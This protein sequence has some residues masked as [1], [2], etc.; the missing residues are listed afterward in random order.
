MV[1]LRSEP[2][3][4][5]ATSASA[6]HTRCKTEQGYGLCLPG[7]QQRALAAL[8]C[9]TEPHSSFGLRV[10]LAVCGLTRESWRV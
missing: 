8:T 10:Y 9:D 5:Q 1:R 3:K 7:N 6:F 4:H 2:Q